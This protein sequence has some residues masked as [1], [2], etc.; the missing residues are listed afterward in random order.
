MRSQ[1]APSLTLAFMVWMPAMA[2]ITARAH[3]PQSLP[4]QPPCKSCQ[5]CVLERSL[6]STLKAKLTHQAQR[7]HCFKVPRSA[8]LVGLLQVHQQRPAP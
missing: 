8:I 6:Q 1:D 3:L 4:Q 2:E 5:P 7:Q